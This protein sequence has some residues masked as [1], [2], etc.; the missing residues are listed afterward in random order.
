MARAL[1]DILTEL[2]SVYSPQ[3][4]VYNAQLA[5]IDPQQTAEM[6]GLDQTK[7]NAFSDIT[8]QANRRGLL[9][10][11]IPINEEAKYTGGTYLPAVANLKGRYAQQKFNLQDAL[12]KI[13]QDQYLK[14]QS[15]YQSEVDR[16]TAAAAGASPTL[17]G[18]GGQVLGDS[19]SIRFRVPGV[20]SSGFAFSDSNGNQAN[21]LQYSQ[22]HGIPFRT[23]LQQMASQ[24]DT[25][26]TAALQFVGQD[27]NADPTKVTSKALADLYYSL[28]G[29]Q[30]GVYT[31]P[32]TSFTNAAN[33]TNA[34]GAY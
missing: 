2:N 29:K 4:D 1:Q 24:G 26:A 30:V 8:D 31:S 6:Q 33:R 25:G 15:I 20:P 9:F 23:L 19:T 3:K 27:G 10:S 28:T 16:D 34:L 17:G 14:G 21:A 32:L 18:T 22:A 12:A 7:T 11:G 13:N 5:Q